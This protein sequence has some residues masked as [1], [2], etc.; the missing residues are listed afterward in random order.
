MHFHFP[1]TA[2][3]DGSCTGRDITNFISYMSA[4]SIGINTCGEVKRLVDKVH[5]YVYGHACYTYMK[6]MLQQNDFWSEFVVHYVANIQNSWTACK[7]TAQLQSSRKVSI[8]S[9]N[10]SFNRSEY[11]MR[12]ILRPDTLQA[13][14]YRTGPFIVASIRSNSLISASS[15]H[16]P[17]FMRTMPSTTESSCPTYN[18]P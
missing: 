17:P 2:F 14:F 4:H 15:G 10:R 8:T 1:F 9:L 7:T 3:L 13:L 5:K 6:T 11:F 12:W 18:S 16:R